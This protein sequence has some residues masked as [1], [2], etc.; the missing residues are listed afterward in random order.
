MRAIATCFLLCLAFATAGCAARPPSAADIAETR[1]K[2]AEAQGASGD[3]LSA[4]ETLLADLTD[5]GEVGSRAR[6]YLGGLPDFEAKLLAQ[7]DAKLASTHLTGPFHYALKVVDALEPAH[8]LSVPAVAEAKAT[9]E[10]R[11]QEALAQGR[12][13]FLERDIAEIPGLNSPEMRRKAFDGLLAQ[14]KA[15]P[16]QAGGAV[17]RLLKIAATTTD[18]AA[19]ERV[20]LGEY[21]ESFKLSREIIEEDVAP[22]YPNAASRMMDALVISIWI[23]SEDRL[24]KE[25]LGAELLKNEDEIEVVDAAEAAE[26][27]VKVTKLEWS[28]YAP[29]PTTRTISYRDY[30]VDTL[31]AVM[32]MPE[33]ASY[34]YEY[35]E[36]QSEI[37]F[38]FEIIVTTPDGTEIANELERGTVTRRFS[39]CSNARVVNVFGG[40]AG[41]SWMA[42]DDMTNRCGRSSSV[43]N[44]TVLRKEVWQRLAKAVA[45]LTTTALPVS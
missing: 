37:T 15:N 18:P 20:T 7:L 44:P 34:M 41:V 10:S 5:P 14:A 39:S 16:A 27:L 35:S 4:A 8:L 25:D 30:E 22:L 26:A 42:N 21:I 29:P 43:P 40:V 12:V 45:K 32:L 3:Y 11:A 36:G 33:N 23:D 24:L 17:R 1:F 38:A 9:I 28:E 2:N 13:T 6:S 31:K 19:Y